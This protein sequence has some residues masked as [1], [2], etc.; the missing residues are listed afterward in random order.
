MLFGYS[1]H[2]EAQGEY[3]MYSPDI[4]RATAK[5]VLKELSMSTLC[6]RLDLVV[7]GMT[8]HAVSI[9]RANVICRCHCMP[10][11]PRLGRAITLPVHHCRQIARLSEALV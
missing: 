2:P 9:A 8:W 3:V 5:C 10:R 7:C 4:Y 1:S 11:M 6:Y